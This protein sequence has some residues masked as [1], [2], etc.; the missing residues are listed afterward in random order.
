MTWILFLVFGGSGAALGGC[1]VQDPG[2]VARVGNEAITAEAVRKTIKRLHLQSGDQT[3]LEL[4]QPLIDR[5]IMKLEAERRGLDRHPTVLAEL[6]KTRRRQLVERVY[7]EEVTQKVVVPEEEIGVYFEQHGLDRKREV[8]AG[9]I[10]VKTLEE[11]RILGRQLQQGAD[12]AELARASSLDT[13]TAAKGGDMGFWQ[14]EDT[15]RSPFVSQLFTLQEGEVS[16]PYR[17]AHGDYHLIKALEERPVGLER[18][19]QQIRAILDRQKKDQRWRA[20]LE[21]QQT[22][23]RLVV[24]EETLSFLL[25]Q[26]R[27]AEEQIPPIAPD[28]HSRILCRYDGGAVGLGTYMGMLQSTPSNRRPAP[29]DSAA[30]AH[31]SLLSSLTT[32]LLPQTAQE[33]G[34]D[35]TA[36]VRSA[37]ERRREE[38]L[39]EILRQVEVEDQV[40]TEDL[41]KNYYDRH[42]AEFV[43]PNRAFAEGG[44]LDSEEE[45]RAVAD[46]TRK[47]EDLA[48]IMQSYTT[49]LGRWRKY[50]V[51]NFSPA[52]APVR[53]GALGAMI[54]AAQG[55]AVGEVRGPVRIAFEKEQSG[56]VVLRVLEQRPAHLLPY[57]DPQVQPIIRN[58]VRYE[59]RQEIETAFEQYLA[60][61]RRKYSPRIVVYKQ[62]LDTLA[63]N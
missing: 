45:A 58:Q 21:E 50:D 63:A 53:Q 55:L 10:T 15:R 3:P 36:T 2:V 22:R 17:D 40:L 9:H 38:L 13:T 49:F 16:E 54:E 14:E 32:V 34:W 27:R 28:D 61:L 19:K 47:G 29:V 56:Y 8:R 43:A 25:R 62:V 18:Q 39:V 30:V 20:Y 7:E 48:A 59:L 57:A 33:H 26:G 42:R 52:D 44:I 37:L 11:A 5:K 41:M 31:F 51:F 1:G 12:F 60:D 23:F 35:Q 6:E 46:R 24:D 4:L